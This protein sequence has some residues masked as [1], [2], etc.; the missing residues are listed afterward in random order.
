M[1]PIV[2]C[3]LAYLAGSIPF[4]LFLAKYGAGVDIRQHGSKNIGATNVGRVLGK[5]W[6]LA[7]LMLDAL[8]GALPVMFL[9]PLF[10]ETS[11]PLFEHLRVGSGMMTILGHMF[12]C[13]LKFRGGKGVATALGVSAV[14]GWESMLAAF[15][16]F[17][18]VFAATRI[19]S[20]S[21]ICAAV[22]YSLSQMWEL[23]PDYFSQTKWAL[24]AFSIVI[25][26]L[27]IIRHRSNIVRLF[28]GIEAKF[29]DKSETTSTS[30]S[31]R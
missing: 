23:S 12:P 19:V 14:L 10:S 25:P 8:K 11:Q 16:T 9:P 30:E 20:I 22:A 13:W 27:I 29:T 18:L 2:C 17:A 3:L 26:L 1:N 21:S 5:K 4:G 31:S 15:V 24:T 28:Q 7:V 6:G